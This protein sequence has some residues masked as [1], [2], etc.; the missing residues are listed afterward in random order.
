MKLKL[1]N[2][3]IYT[4][5]LSLFIFSFNSGLKITDQLN[6]FVLF[7]CPVIFFNLILIFF[8]NNRFKI[9]NFNFTNKLMFLF[10]LIIIFTAF[11]R[12]WGFEA[13]G[14]KMSGGM[15]YIKLLILILFF[16]TIS[17][18]K[19]NEN[20]INFL[21]KIFLISTCLPFISDV[22]KILFGYDNFISKFIIGSTTIEDY[23][24]KYKTGGLLRI[25]SCSGLSVFVTI[26]MLMFKNF[27]NENG[28]IIYKKRFILYLLIEIILISLS[29]H[30]MTII[31]NSLLFFLYFKFIINY[32]FNFKYIFKL[33]TLIFILFF[34]IIIFYEKLPFFIQRI[35]SFLPFLKNSEISADVSDSNLF[36]ILLWLNAYNLLPKYFWIGKGFA[37]INNHVSGSNYFEIIEEFTNY[38]AFHNGPIGLIINLGIGGFITGIVLLIKF[39]LKCYKYLLNSENSNVIIKIYYLYVIKSI[40]IFIFIYG[41]L[42]TNFQEVLFCVIILK[43]TSVYNTSKKNFK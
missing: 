21:L 39:V 1:F 36:R 27:L 4:L 14:S 38:G 41:D 28:K 23:W 20:Y 17:K 34:I 26:Y 9:N 24:E 22:F 25:Q 15:V 6:L 30:R 7:A 29:G 37:F 11:Y 16:L 13:F 42:Q 18:Y 19:L 8:T 3:N 31:E 33:I 12:G 43:I 40:I 5:F 2:L 35:F 10:F 32:K